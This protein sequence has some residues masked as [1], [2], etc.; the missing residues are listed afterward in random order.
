MLDVESRGV[1]QQLSVPMTISGFFRG[2]RLVGRSQC[3]CEKIGMFLNAVYLWIL[4]L[5]LQVA[6]RTP[7]LAGSKG[8]RSL[9]CSV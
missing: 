2:C 9:A 8:T 6:V 4:I 1:S 5:A 7:C 3:F